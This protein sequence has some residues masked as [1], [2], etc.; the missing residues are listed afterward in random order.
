[1]PPPACYHRLHPARHPEGAM[2]QIDS[3]IISQ[4]LNVNAS[5]VSDALDRLGIEGHPQGV[6]PIFPTTK[7]CG[8]A[9]TLKL[10]PAGK[11]GECTVSGSLRAIMNGGAGAVHV[12]DASECTNVISVGG[13]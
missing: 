8:P 9:A 13:D 5:N 10:V 1:M 3:R 12:V 6:L 4:F 7:I 11:G 2:A